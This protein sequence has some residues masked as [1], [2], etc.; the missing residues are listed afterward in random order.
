MYLYYVYCGALGKEKSHIGSSVCYIPL[1]SNMLRTDYPK[2]SVP[3]I[4][5]GLREIWGV[6]VYVIPRSTFRE[7][8]PWSEKDYLR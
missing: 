4:N 5:F 1:H 6:L 3:A 2:P 7:T 8:G